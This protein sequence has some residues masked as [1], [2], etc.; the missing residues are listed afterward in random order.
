MQFFS[1]HLF[2]LTASG[3]EKTTT[4]LNLIPTGGTRF[5]GTIDSGVGK[6]VTKIEYK[7]TY[8]DKEGKTV[9]FFVSLYLCFFVSLF[10]CF[11]VSLVVQNVKDDA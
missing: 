8:Q 2:T 10:L 5:I 1:F 6:S 7:F 11:F 9:R 3:V 4:T